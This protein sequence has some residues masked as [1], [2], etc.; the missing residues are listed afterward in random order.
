MPSIF[1]QSVLIGLVFSFR[2]ACNSAAIGQLAHSFVVGHRLGVC[3][4]CHVPYP[5]AYW[6]AV[7]VAVAKVTMEFVLL[8]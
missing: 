1:L 3:Q 4:K 7:D 8:Y 2:P 6:A 5:K